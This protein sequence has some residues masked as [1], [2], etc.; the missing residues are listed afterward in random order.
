MKF[1][2]YVVFI[3]VWG[4]AVYRP[5]AH[6]VWGPGGWIAELARSTLPVGPW[7][8]SALASALVAAAFLG[9]RRRNA[10]GSA[11]EAP[12]N[13]PLV[14]LGASLLWFGWFG[15]NAGSRAGRQR[16]WRPWLW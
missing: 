15:F 14:V 11:T 16:L 13:V 3:A 12:H 10:P 8:T 5:I 7:S 1:R 6:W 2:A 4:L 9:P